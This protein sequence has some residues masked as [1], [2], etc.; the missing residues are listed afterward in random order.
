MLFSLCAFLAFGLSIRFPFS[1]FD[2]LFP[3]CHSLLIPGNF[4]LSSS[5]SF[6]LFVEVFLSIFV[7]F[8]YSISCFLFIYLTLPSSSFLSDMFCNIFC[9]MI[10]SLGLISLSLSYSNFVS[11]DIRLKLVNVFVEHDFLILALL[12]KIYFRITKFFFSYMSRAKYLTHFSS[13]SLEKL[14]KSA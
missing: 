6:Y 11:D 3:C 8:F 5:Y 10:F 1:F 14:E 12:K 9:E 4:F 13:H 2:S 7:F